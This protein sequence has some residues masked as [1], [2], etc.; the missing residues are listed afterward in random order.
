MQS[1]RPIRT[2]LGFDHPPPPSSQAQLIP[3]GP[4]SKSV[5]SR[6]QFHTQLMGE[7]PNPLFT[8]CHLNSFPG[9]WPGFKVEDKRE[10]NPGQLRP[11]FKNSC[12]DHNS[13]STVQSALLCARQALRGAPREPSLLKNLPSTRRNVNRTDTEKVAVS[14]HS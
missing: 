14:N 9:C 5:Y 6:R 11:E 10:Q 3:R 4:P 8:R 7:R 2:L 13:G 1:P 12:I